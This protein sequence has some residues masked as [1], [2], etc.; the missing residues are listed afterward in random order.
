MRVKNSLRN[1]IY[2]YG[3][4]ALIV[5]L[6]FIVRRVFLDVLK[7]DYLGYDGLFTSIFSFL[8]LSEMGIAT[9]ITYHMYSEI[10]SDNKENIRKLLYTYKMI[11][12]VVGAFVLLAGIVASLFLPL[13]LNDRQKESW[14][15]IYTI[16]FLQLLATLCT[17]FFAY[18]RILFITH[19]RLYV[20]TVV[21]T[22][23][24]IVSVI[25]RMMILLYLRN[26]IVYL[27][28]AIA[29][30]VTSNLIISLRAKKEY[31]DLLEEKVSTAYMKEL[32]LFHD[33][34]NMM[35]MKIAATLYG[36]SDD[37]I[38]TYILGVATNGIVSNYKMITGK[39]QELILSLF[40][41]LQASIGNLVY[42]NDKEKEKGIDFFYA[43]DMIGFF[44][45]LICA[46][47]LISIG[48]PFVLLWLK[49]E[50]LLLPYSCLMA[51]GI[52]MFI[53]LCNNPMNFFRNT[54]GHFETDRNYMIISAVVNIVLSIALC[55]P[56]G[57]TG[58]FIATII[59][60]LFIYAGRTIV[61]FRYYI[62]K[63]CT[64][65]LILVILRF[66]ILG[67]SIGI[68]FILGNMATANISM[69]LL[70]VLIKGV[71]SVAV[72]FAFFMISGIRTKA[73]GVIVLYVKRVLGM[74]VGRKK[75]A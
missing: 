74:L 15:F 52:N 53:A 23:V 10:A 39:I 28:I 56:Y 29:A 50:E 3:S 5:I 1:M 68:S 42:D 38:V 62:K 67:A 16:Y 51:L 12:R 49:K 36:A 25:A 47:G 64:G 54:L 2:I 70:E 48:Q 33:V 6:N 73:F 41:S 37:I 32:D 22:S 75:E 71:I 7:V 4:T 59:G 66:V 26:Y 46:T 11:Y 30:N 65:Y 34:K 40:N 60:H 44:F 13:I 8:N 55:I 18:R 72:S 63:P 14:L 61:V 45:G 57:I 21:D 24:N 27:I 17:Y 58:V 43:L 31:P 20:C 9:I 69:L 35:M 19:Q